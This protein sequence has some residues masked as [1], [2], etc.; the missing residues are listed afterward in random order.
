MVPSCADMIPILK[1][2]MF[3]EGHWK[4]IKRDFLYNFSVQE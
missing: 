4:V 2:T 1:T 3:I